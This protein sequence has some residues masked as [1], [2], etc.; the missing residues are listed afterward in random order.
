VPGVLSYTAPNGINHDLAVRLSSNGNKF[1]VYDNGVLVQQAVVGPT[2]SIQITGGD[3]SDRLTLDYSLGVFVRPVTFNGGPSGTDVIAVSANGDFTLTGEPKS[4]KLS[5]TVGSS[6]TLNNVARAELTGGAGNNRLDAGGFTGSVMLAGGDGDDILIGAAGIDVLEGGDG[7]NTIISRTGGD[8]A[9]H[10]AKGDDYY[11]LDPG[12]TITV[13]DDGGNDTINLGGIPGGVSVS[14]GGSDGSVVELGVPEPGAI[15]IVGSIETLL[16]TAADDIFAATN[17]TDTGLI[18]T[19]VGV[20]GKDLFIDL[21]K[22]ERLNFHGGP[23]D[24]T[25]QLDPG[26]TIT[27]TDDGGNDTINLGS[28]GGPATVVLGEGDGAV[29]VP[30]GTANIVGA[31]E[32]VIGTS[33]DDTIVGNSLSNTINGGDGNDT[34]NG[35]GGKDIIDGGTGSDT[36]DAGLDNDRI[37]VVPGSTETVIDS[38]GIDTLDFSGA[39]RGITLNLASSGGQTIDAAGNKIKLVGTFENVIGTPFDD[40]INGNQ[41]NNLLLGMGGNDN[42]SGHAGQDILIGGAGIDRINAGADDDLLI[43][44]VTTFDGNLPALLK[45]QEEWTSGSSYA[46][47]VAH[48]RGAS[49]GL[50]GSNFLVFG[51][52]VIDDGAADTL[53]GS[54]QLDWF[55]VFSGDTVTDNNQNEFVN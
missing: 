51:V 23:G 50:N 14:L 16:G 33:F 19:F 31:I 40:N 17:T 36:I 20:G 8:D 3:R 55:F 32:N 30:G 11:D 2:D 15:N 10:G 46:D 52:T 1:E 35:G 29:S 45:I 4:G 43:G 5:A 54:Q 47:R 41:A 26:S 18:Q 38:G 9:V 12:S 7:N 37:I 27:V 48:L 53:T 49:G 34:I 21:S 25:F 13:T 28:A 22:A 44:G 42:L 39:H 24:D 6:V